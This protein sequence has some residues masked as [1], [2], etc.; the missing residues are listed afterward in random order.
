MIDKACSKLPRSINE[1]CVQFVDAYEPALVA[2]LAQEIDPSQICPLIKACPSSKTQDVEVFMQ[3]ESDG[4]KCPL[5]LFAVSKLEEMVKDKKTEVRGIIALFVEGATKK[6]VPKET[7]FEK[8]TK[9]N[10][11]IYFLIKSKTMILV[12]M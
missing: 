1:T 3:Q 9:F 10:V 11:H 5:C 4:S 7:T 6:I 2:I 12:H 8:L